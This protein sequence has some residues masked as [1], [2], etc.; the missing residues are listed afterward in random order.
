M[1][2]KDR[3]P[4]KFW[5]GLAATALACSVLPVAAQRAPQRAGG[6][7]AVEAMRELHYR[8][9]N[10]VDAV[11]P[12][13]GDV[14][15]VYGLTTP[16]Y[17]GRWAQKVGPEGRVYAVYRIEE[18]YRARRDAGSEVLGGQVTPIFAADGDAHLEAAT[19]DLVIVADVFGFFLREMDL[20]RQAGAALRSGGRLIQVRSNKLIESDTQRRYQ[21]SKIELEGRAEILERNRR[22]LRV[23]Q[24][25]FRFVGE[26]AVFEARTVRVFENL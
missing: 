26:L 17:L 16:D 8:V 7:K 1:P 4:R 13:P 3:R 10:L 12:Q 25:G 5:I 2:K 21:G 23:N 18:D 20:Y 14:V 6:Q 15:V 9:Q 22:L 19:V 24:F 11:A